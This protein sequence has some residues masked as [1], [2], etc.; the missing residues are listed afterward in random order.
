LDDNIHEQL[1]HFTTQGVFRYPFVIIHM[2]LFQRGDLLHIQLQKQDDRGMDQSTIYWTE[3]FKANST[4]CTSSNFSD[5]FIHPVLQLI[6]SQTEP[7][8]NEEIKKTMHLSYHTKTCDWY[9]YHNYTEIKVYGSELAPYKLPKYVIM[10]I[11]SLE[12][13]R[14]KIDM[15]ELHFVSAKKKS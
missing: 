14:Q 11:F 8:I 15:D 9:L 3:L 7:R 4:K 13:I 10:R 6:N 12:Y 1:I 2:F 5:L